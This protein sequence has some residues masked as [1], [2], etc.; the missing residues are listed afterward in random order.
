M[1]NNVIKLGLNSTSCLKKLVEYEPVYLWEDQSSYI[2]N[3]LPPLITANSR[4]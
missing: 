1:L 2:H 3:S 4:D